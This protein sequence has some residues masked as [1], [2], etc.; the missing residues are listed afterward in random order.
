MCQESSRGIG[1]KRKI[2]RFKEKVF[3]DA[4]RPGARV[5]PMVIA[6][7]VTM[8]IIINAMKRHI[9]ARFNPCPIRKPVCANKAINP[10]MLKIR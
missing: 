7:V 8:P 9:R 3:T 5:A 4:E 1:Q 10:I 2:C 6:R